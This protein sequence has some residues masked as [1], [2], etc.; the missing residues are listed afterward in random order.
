M[1]NE[2]VIDV[3]NE[4]PLYIQV[5]DFILR[6]IKDNTFLVGEAIPPER[7]LSDQLD[8]SRYTIRKAIQELVQDGYLYRVQGNGT[9]VFSKEKPGRKTSNEIGVILPFY[10]GVSLEI[11]EGIEASFESIN[12]RFTVSNSR[13][14]YKREARSIQKMK[15][16]GVNGL[17]ICPAEDQKDSTIIADLKSEGF[18]FVLVDRRLQYCET[19]CVM[20]DNISG[21]YKAAEYLIKLGHKK[22]AFIK[23]EYIKTSSIEDRIIGYKSALQQYGLDDDSRLILSYNLSLE[24]EEVYSRIHKFIQEKEPTAVIAV[25]DKVALDIV[26]MSREKN[27]NIPKDL[28]LITFDN[29]DIVKHLQVPLTSVVQSTEDIG[30]KAVELLVEKVNNKDEQNKIVQQIY[31]PVELVIRDSCSELV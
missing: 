21:G 25:H 11:L 14:N 22:I 23:N 30:K 24:K 19:D 4:K 1:E 3:N 2:K 28:S 5:K 7:D 16:D 12:Y 20:S 18:P 31:Y 26:K 10:E 8:V 13:D 29:T 15:S 6:N 9:F 27:I 17:I